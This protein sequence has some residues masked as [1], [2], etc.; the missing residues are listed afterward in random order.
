GRWAPPRPGHLVPPLPWVW[1]LR[2]APRAAS[3]EERALDEALAGLSAP[4]RAAYVLRVLER[5]PGPDTRDLLDAADVPDPGAA[6]AQAGRVRANATSPDGRPLLGSAG[7]DPCWLQVRPTDLMRRRQHLRAAV[8]GA[9]VLVVCG[10]LLG[11][12]GGR[13]GDDTPAYARNPAVE[14]AMDPATLT[15][16]APTAWRRATRADFSAWPARGDRTGDTALLRRALAMW[17]HPDHAVHLSATP[18]TPPGP[19]AGPAQLLFAG[20]VDRAAVVVLYDGLRVVRYAE[21]EADGGTL[22]LD[23]ARVDAATAATATALVIGRA[24]G[25]VRFLTAPWLRQAAV[26]DLLRPGDPARPLPRTQDGVTAPV[27][28]P[29]QARGCRSWTALQLGPHLVTD[30][31]ELVPARLTYGEPGPG[32]GRDATGEAARAGWAHAACHLPLMRGRGVRAVNAWPFAAQRLP[33]GDGTAAWS[34]L[35]G[36]TWRGAGSR[37]MAQFRPPTAAPGGQAAIVASADGSAACGPREPRVLAGVLWKSAA[38]RWYVLGAGSR[39]VIAI[40]A[41]GGAHGVASGRLL[42]LPADPG[43]RAELVGRLTDGRR[44]A[45][46]H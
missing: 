34:C 29:A 15:R 11:M 4:A 31:G 43:S 36:E 8:A 37:V 24:H 5:L 2:L 7:F 44:L 18:G 21:S 22:A 12:P 14:Q 32:G 25:D 39:Q 46:L 28:S 1:G 42:A 6:L 23:L 40:V 41:D 35:R 20:E 13:W 45:A 26:R 33:E 16:A 9:A 10:A 3:P 27:A 19:P 38:G 30:L 17:A